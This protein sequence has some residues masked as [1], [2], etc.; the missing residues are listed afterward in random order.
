LNTNSLISISCISD[1][2]LPRY[3]VFS[4]FAQDRAKL[5][6]NVHILS[7][8]FIHSGLNQ[9]M[10]PNVS[11]LKWLQPVKGL[12]ASF[13][14]YSLMIRTFWWTLVFVLGL[15]LAWSDYFDYMIFQ[16]HVFWWFSL[17]TNFIY[18]LCGARSWWNL[19]FN[20]KWF[21]LL[22]LWWP[23]R[24]HTEKTLLSGHSWL[25]LWKILAFC[26]MLGNVTL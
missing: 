3:N 5:H 24:G 6:K 23:L 9:G 26:L 10:R 12:I 7:I 17:E 19:F 20:R 18:L 22:L 4:Y 11:P 16:E 25:M 13:F 2:H 14:S 1:L 15:A 8:C 21:L